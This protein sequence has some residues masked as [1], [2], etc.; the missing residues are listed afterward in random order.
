MVKSPGQSQTNNKKSWP[1]NTSSTI[2]QTTFPRLKL[3]LPVLLVLAVALMLSTNVARAALPVIDLFNATYASGAVADGN[4]PAVQ[5]LSDSGIIGGSSVVTTTNV[6]QSTG[7]EMT[8]TISGGSLSGTTVGTGSPIG[9]HE[10]RYDNFSNLDLTDSGTYDRF[11]LREAF[12]A[13]AGLDYNVTIQVSEDSGT[14][15]SAMTTINSATPSDIEVLFN[16]FSPAFDFTDVDAIVV[17]FQALMSNSD[18]TAR[19]QLEAIELDGPLPEPTIGKIATLNDSDGNGLANVGETIDYTITVSGILAAVTDF[20]ITDTYDPSLV[21]LG[22]VLSNPTPTSMDLSSA[23]SIALDYSGNT[24]PTVIITYTATII[25]LPVAG[26]IPNTATFESSTFY[27]GQIFEDMAEVDSDDGI[28]FTKTDTFLTDA[29]ANSRADIGDV[30]RYTLFLENDS[31]DGIF[32]VTIEDLLPD[33]LAFAT[34]DVATSTST[35]GAASAV[36][37][38]A[39][40]DPGGQIFV[41]TDGS[42]SLFTGSNATITI[43]VVV[44]DIVSSQLVNQASLD[45][46][47][48]EDPFGI[49]SDDPDT[50]AP[51]DPT[52]TPVNTPSDDD[53]DGDPDPGPEPPDPI[54]IIVTEETPEP[55]EE[56]PEPTDEPEEEEEEEDVFLPGAPP[57]EVTSSVTPATPTATLEPT[58]TP[59]PEPGFIPTITP[60]PEP[61]VEVACSFVA[62]EIQD[63]RWQQQYRRERRPS[64]F[65]PVNGADLEVLECPEPP[66]GVICFPPTDNLL[67][68]A[69][70]DV[71]NVQLID[72]DGNELQIF[73]APGEVVENEVCVNFDTVAAGAVCGDGC[74]LAPIIVQDGGFVLDRPLLIGIPVLLIVGLLLWLFIVLLVRRRREEADTDQLDSDVEQ[75]Q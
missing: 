10:I 38:T 27:P 16:S 14:T 51:Q 39:S 66:T 24:S 4:S 25:S 13:E 12:A 54:I 58:S 22:S 37:M 47:I 52:N 32:S 46:E 33:G 64:T 50:P 19:F 67:A 49:S 29:N 55:T 9:T 45:G 1:L 11:V 23:G 41:E 18:V 35:T 71:E 36:D 70:S 57:V 63:A 30:I 73:M 69:E 59:T 7:L 21:T 56:T 65:I 6:V 20:R 8:T 26:V 40:I 34:G 60:T 75:T 2:S 3:L 62:Y 15:A 72:I 43:D 68:L 61:I 28:T 42:F 44:V 53:D 74:S 48:G 17:T 31:P 5:D